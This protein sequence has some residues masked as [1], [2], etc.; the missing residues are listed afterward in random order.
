M[1]AN[2]ENISTKALRNKRRNQRRKDARIVQ[3]VSKQVGADSQKVR[4]LLVN[5]KK[6]NKTAITTIEDLQQSL[7]EIGFWEKFSDSGMGNENFQAVCKNCPNY[8]KDICAEL[9]KVFDRNHD[10]T[11]TAKEFLAGSIQSQDAEGTKE[12]EL[13]FDGWDEDGSGTLS[14]AEIKKLWQTR[15]TSEISVTTLVIRNQAYEH[16]LSFGAQYLEAF[17]SDFTQEKLEKYATEK[18]ASN[19]NEWIGINRAT[20]DERIDQTVEKIFEKAD[21]DKSGTLSKEEFIKFFCDSTTLYEIRGGSHENEAADKFFAEKYLE[22]FYGFLF[23]TDNKKLNACGEAIRYILAP[24]GD[25]PLVSVDIWE[26][27]REIFYKAIG[28]ETTVPEIPEQ[29]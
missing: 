10:G 1:S 23:E 16:R 6:Q 18:A 19:T 12:A 17:P 8:K 11:I 3:S 28:V 27:V 29:E 15:R 13:L 9:F 26:I 4:D 5:W 22:G 2:T 24:S 21:A 7:E 20:E 14:K 25:S